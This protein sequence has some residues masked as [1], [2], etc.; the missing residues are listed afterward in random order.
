MC[1]PVWLCPWLQGYFG[2]V[3]DEIYIKVRPINKGLESF[4][5]ETGMKGFLNK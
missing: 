5:K 3:P 2:E 1:L 4:V